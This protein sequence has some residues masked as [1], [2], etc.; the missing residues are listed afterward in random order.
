LSGAHKR[1]HGEMK[2]Q[3]WML[4]SRDTMGFLYIVDTFGDKTF[5]KGHKE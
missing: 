3:N 4:Y 5:V 2:R 1:A